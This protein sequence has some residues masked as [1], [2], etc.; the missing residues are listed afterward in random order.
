MARSKPK[1][2]SLQ[3]LEN[4]ISSL[5]QNQ[6][7][8]AG[9]M[10]YIKKHLDKIWEHVVSTND[11]L[12]TLEIQA[13]LVARL[14]STL[15]VEKLGVSSFSLLKM[16][17]RIEKDT[18][19]ADQIQHLEHLYRLEPKESVVKPSPKKRRPRKK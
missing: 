12:Q 9:D 16:I 3:S 7:V 8:Q 4:M 11:R 13:N 18:I 19:A 2:L 10:V 1:Q 5:E 17:K 14:I 6:K 15:A